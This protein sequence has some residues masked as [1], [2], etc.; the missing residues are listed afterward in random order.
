VAID[1]LDPRFVKTLMQVVMLSLLGGKLFSEIWLKRK[2]KKKESRM[3]GRGII[4]RSAALRIAPSLRK[5]LVHVQCDEKLFWPVQENEKFGRFKGGL[6][7]QARQS[8]SVL[9]GKRFH[10]GLG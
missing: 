8:F 3:C 4:Y 10:F 9:L 6:V 7:I 5:S 1:G 2:G